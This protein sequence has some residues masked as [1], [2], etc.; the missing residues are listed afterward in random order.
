MRR[1]LALGNKVKLVGGGSRLLGLTHHGGVDAADSEGG[2]A[3]VAVC[4]SRSV[5]L[6]RTTQ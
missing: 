4:R 6:S 1:A 5:S 2:D 3:G